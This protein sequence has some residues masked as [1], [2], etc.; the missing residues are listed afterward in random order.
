ME[1]AGEE[2]VRAFAEAVTSGD[3]E[4]A[5]AVSDPEIEFLSVLAVSGR[6][7]HG[8]D[9]VRQYFADVAAA[10]SEWRVELHRVVP[11]P[12]GRVM[13][14]MTMHFRGKESGAAFSDETAHVWTLR[15]G[16]LLRN[17]PYRDP[18]EALRAVGLKR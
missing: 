6:A 2:A 16:K 9:G 17:E 3:P 12:D 5:V 1:S 4:A 8:H 7:Y 18:D 15:D 13:I 14:S 11:A 10:W